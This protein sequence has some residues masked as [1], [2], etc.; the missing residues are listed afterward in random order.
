M[1]ANT[2]SFE[3]MSVK[4]IGASVAFMQNSEL[5]SP[6]CV[7]DGGLRC[8]VMHVHKVLLSLASCILLLCICN[9]LC[10]GTHWCMALPTLVLCVQG[11][12]WLGLE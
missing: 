9:N 6:V 2:F 12:W 4:V 5:V 10:M 3:E 1:H 7:S 8:V 11:E